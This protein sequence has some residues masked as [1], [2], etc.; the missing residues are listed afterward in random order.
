VVSRVFAGNRFE[1]PTGTNVYA[2][3]YTSERWHF[4]PIAG[5]IT[6]IRCVDFNVY[7]NADG[8]ITAGAAHNVKRTIEYPAGVFHT[9]SW[10]GVAT[11]SK[12]NAIVKQRADVLQSSVDGKPLS[13]PA[14]AL[15]GERTVN[16]SNGIAL[17]TVVY[18]AACTVLGIPDGNVASDQG[19]SG[20]INPT[21]G[22]RTFGSFYIEAEIIGV[23]GARSYVAFGDSLTFGTGDEQAS[24]PKYSSGIIPRLFDK[25]GLPYLKISIGNLT[26]SGLATNGA[27]TLATLLDGAPFTDGVNA[28]GVND[29][30]TYGNADV[31][32]MFSRFQSLYGLF[33]GKRVH[34]Q[35]ITPRT[36]SNDGY[37]TPGGQS[38]KTGM[39]TLPACNDLIRVGLPNVHNV[40]DRADSA[41]SAR[42][43]NVWGGPPWPPVKTDGVHS[44]S[45]KN[46]NEVAVLTLPA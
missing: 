19:N 43:S 38:P 42:N 16:L 12:P 36:D 35:T 24:G 21:T 22:T 20:T 10:G 41:M 5:T 37:T 17:P 32:L 31:P 29:F 40:I 28:L 4:A 18:P 11:L 3:P 1:I 23:D 13:I 7:L 46:A 27:A 39:A 8:T 6:N 30:A 34:Q 25:Y 26:A 15:F 33:A 9:V 2:S 44:V 45:A 14:A